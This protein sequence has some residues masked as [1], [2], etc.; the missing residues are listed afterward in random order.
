M[1]TVRALAAIPLMTLCLIACSD[2]K[3]DTTPTTAPDTTTPPAA[4]VI[5][6][7]T[8]GTDS[9]EDRIE[10]VALGTE[11]TLNITDPAENQTYHVHGYDFEQEVAAGHTAT[12]SFTA[13]QAGRFEVESHTTEA[14]L[15][16]I[17]VS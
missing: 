2:D 11:I 1:K 3:S 4:S 12:F 5:I 7:V 6:D 14:V 13:D 15:V 17:E 9:G 8:V 16:V 10:H